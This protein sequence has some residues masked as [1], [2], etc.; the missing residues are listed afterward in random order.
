[1]MLELTAGSSLWFGEDK[2]DDVQISGSMGIPGRFA[3]DYQVGSALIASQPTK[4]IQTF[5]LLACPGS[6][7]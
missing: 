7:F 5:A 3:G 2:H 1:M 4:K 6:K